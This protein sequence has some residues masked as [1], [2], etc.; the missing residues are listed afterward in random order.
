MHRFPLFAFGLGLVLSLAATAARVDA[1]TWQ[2]GISANGRSANGM[3][4]AG[5]KSLTVGCGQHMGSTLSVVLTGGPHP[6]M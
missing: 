5:G 6:G 4:M 3:V 1:Q 2:S